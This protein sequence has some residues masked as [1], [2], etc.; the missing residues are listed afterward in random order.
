MVGKAERQL[1]DILLRAVGPDKA[2]VAL[3]AFGSSPS[4]SVRVNPSKIGDPAAFV[5]DNFG[6]DS[7][8]V[9]WSPFGY[10]LSSRPS[11]TLDPLLHCGCYY[12]QDSSAMAVGHVF[13]RP[14]NFPAPGSVLSGYLTF[15]PHPE[16]RP[17][18]W[19]R[20]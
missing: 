3:A 2:E 19:P 13:R 14:W 8:P 9:L 7:E 5:A 20:R 15:A 17:R 18:T 6:G 4:V 16:E 1:E 12:V 10:T 11:F